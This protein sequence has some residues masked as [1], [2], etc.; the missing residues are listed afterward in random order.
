MELPIVAGTVTTVLFASSMI[1][2]LAHTAYILSLPAGPY[3]ST[4]PAL[5]G[6][7]STKAPIASE[8]LP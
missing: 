3:R 6:S 5:T 4:E 7:D 2:M 1:P 8:A